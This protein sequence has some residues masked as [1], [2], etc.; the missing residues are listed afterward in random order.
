MVIVNESIRFTIVERPFSKYGIT[1]MNSNLQSQ[2]KCSWNCHNHT[3]YCKQ[4][5]VK[6]MKPYFTIIDPIYFG[7]I[8]ILGATGNYGLANII[9]LV[10]L[11]P[12]FMLILLIKS[13]NLQQKIK[14]LKNHD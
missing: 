5:H 10:I 1:A 8:K 7:I 6:F 4:F 2:E 9:F 14:E 13:I 11:W 3:A 12:F